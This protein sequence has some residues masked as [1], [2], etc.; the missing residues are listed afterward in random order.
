MEYD[1]QTSDGQNE[2]EQNKWIIKIADLLTRLE[3]YRATT[4][5]INLK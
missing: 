2:P 3:S 5:T 4:T 1:Q